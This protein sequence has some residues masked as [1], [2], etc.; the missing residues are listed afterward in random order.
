MSMSEI[1]GGVILEEGV[2]TFRGGEDRGQGQ[3]IRVKSNTKPHGLILSFISQFILVLKLI[4]S[5]CKANFTKSDHVFPA[6]GSTILFHL[7][8]N[9]KLRI[10]SI[11]NTV[12]IYK[13]PTNEIE[14][15]SSSIWK[16]PF[17]VSFTH[18]MCISWI[19][20]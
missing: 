16:C 19:S 13:W 1:V 7:W 14:F 9:F 4:Y 20:S 6:T 12:V 17:I 11:K 10:C 3:K 2:R 15:F 5:W 18:S 8:V